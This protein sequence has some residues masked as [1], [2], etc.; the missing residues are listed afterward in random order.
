MMEEADFSEIVA[1]PLQSQSL[2]LENIHSSRSVDLLNCCWPSPAQSF[3][4][5]GLVEIFDKVFF[6]S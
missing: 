4:A 1:E 6:L 3:L 2:L 5:S